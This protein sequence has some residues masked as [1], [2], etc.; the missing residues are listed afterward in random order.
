MTDLPQGW[1]APNP[2]WADRLA[3][4]FRKELTPR[5]PLHSAGFTVRAVYGDDSVLVEAPALAPSFYVL[6]LS[7]SDAPPRDPH[8][9]WDLTELEAIFG[10]APDDVDEVSLW[11]R[12]DT[13]S[14]A[15]FVQHLWG[16]GQIVQALDPTEH[17]LPASARALAEHGWTQVTGPLSPRA[18]SEG[19]LVPTGQRVEY[20]VR[21]ILDDFM[22]FRSI[23]T[24][25]EPIA[26]RKLIPD[27][28]LLLEF[29]TRAELEAALPSSAYCRFI[30]PM[31]P[32]YGLAGFPRNAT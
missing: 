18:W 6:H 16:G 5:H 7:W 23:E 29:E 12:E 19:Q 17:P 1:T 22:L 8:A 30:S 2:A 14:G 24:P 21:P 26:L 25:G 4:R 11:V 31:A 27:E 3:H 13:R 28:P 9:L 32:R 10:P 20:W 15:V